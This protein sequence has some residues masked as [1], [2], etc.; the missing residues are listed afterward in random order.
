[1]SKSTNLLFGRLLKKKNARKRVSVTVH[2]AVLSAGESQ[3]GKRA[4]IN[5]AE[6]N[7]APPCWHCGNYHEG[8]V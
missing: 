3:C 1:M 8:G 7:G 5:A 6:A 4:I 2:E